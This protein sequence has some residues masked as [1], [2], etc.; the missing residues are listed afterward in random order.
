MAVRYPN[1]VRHTNEAG[2]ILSLKIKTMDGEQRRFTV[3]IGGRGAIIAS[4]IRL[5]PH[6]RLTVVAA[7]NQVSPER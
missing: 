7:D 3:D 6:R 5:V 1:L 4:M 2:S